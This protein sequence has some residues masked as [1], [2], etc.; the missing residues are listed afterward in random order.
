VQSDPV[1]L[2]GGPN[3]YGYVH[4]SPIVSVDYFGLDCHYV[5]GGYFDKPV[6]VKIKDEVSEWKSRCFPAPRGTAGLPDPLDGPHRRGSRRP[7]PIPPDFEWERKC[8]NEFIIYEPAEFKVVSSK[9]QYQWLECVECS[10]KSTIS[11]PDTPA[12]TLPKY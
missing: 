5:F 6:L 9:W 2:F 7:I 10:G 12:N 3:T 1:G 8:V 4:G 11:L